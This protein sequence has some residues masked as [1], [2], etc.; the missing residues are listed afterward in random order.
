MV[1]FMYHVIITIEI[2]A[3]ILENTRSLPKMCTNLVGL[4]V[5]VFIYELYEVHNRLLAVQSWQL[6][7]KVSQVASHH[8]NKCKPFQ[9][10]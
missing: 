5:V 8:A 7:H 4:S 9:G 1:E 3:K 10:Y 6:D 2:S